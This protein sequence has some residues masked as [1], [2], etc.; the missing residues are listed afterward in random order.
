MTDY[1]V[2]QAADLVGL[3]PAAVQV[4]QQQGLITATAQG[5][6]DASALQWLSR[7]KRLRLSGMA[8]SQIAAYVA[9]NR[10][11]GQPVATDQSQGQYTRFLAESMPP[12]T[13]DYSD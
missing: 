8:L 9:Q 1:T 7:I 11:D 12:L 6:L 2:Q 13:W 10:V 3:T 5:T 4:Y